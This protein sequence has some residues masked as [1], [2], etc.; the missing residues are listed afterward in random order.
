MENIFESLK[1]TKYE[2]IYK[3]QFESQR[4]LFVSEALKRD[5]R[6]GITFCSWLL[7]LELNAA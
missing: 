7:L 4:E 5:R 2:D 1:D 6:V 3:Q